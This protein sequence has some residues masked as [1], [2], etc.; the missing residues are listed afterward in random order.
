MQIDAPAHKTAG[1]GRRSGRGRVSGG[2]GGDGGGDSGGAR[3]ARAGRAR[4]AFEG[5]AERLL[6]THLGK[7]GGSR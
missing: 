4:R 1:R 6:A 7:L 5:A 3:M 2:G